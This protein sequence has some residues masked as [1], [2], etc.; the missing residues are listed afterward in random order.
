[1]WC[2]ALV[3]LDEIIFPAVSDCYDPSL[4]HRGPHLKNWSDETSLVAS[5]AWQTR[6]VPCWS[7]PLRAS[8]LEPLACTRACPGAAFFLA[9]N[10]RHVRAGF[11]S[12]GRR[13]K[14]SGCSRWPQQ[15][16]RVMCRASIFVLGARLGRRMFFSSLCAGT[17][18]LTRMLLLL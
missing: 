1:M 18:A 3:R 16:A 17:T 13:R 15:S 11:S 14:P 2:L 5:N 10:Y 4:S 7:M 9:A 6:R 12:L 8:I